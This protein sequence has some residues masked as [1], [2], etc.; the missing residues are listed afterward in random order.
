[1]D[2]RLPIFPLIA[3][4][5][6]TNA[7]AA[8]AEPP[9]RIEKPANSSPAQ[10]EKPPLNFYVAK[11]PDD[12][13]GAGCNEWIAA[14]GRF[15]FESYQRLRAFLNRLSGRKLPIYFSSP[16]GMVSQALAIGRLLRERGLTAGVASTTPQGCEPPADKEEACL[17]LKHSGRAVTAAWNAIDANCNSS[18]VYALLGGKQRQVPPGARLGVHSGKVLRV[19]RVGG[20]VKNVTDETSAPRTKAKAH[21]IDVELRRYAREMGIDP[22]LIDEAEKIPFEQVRYLSRDEIARFGIDARPLIET[23][24]TVVDVPSKPL[25][26]FTFMVEAKGGNNKEFRTGILRLACSSAATLAV[27]YIRGLAGDEIGH[28]ATIKL[29][30]S[31]RDLVFPRIGKVS[32]IDALDNG[33]TF[34]SR[35]VRAP[36]DFFDKAAAAE[37]IDIVVTDLADPAL[38]PR[39]RRLSTSGL[40]SA[41]E[42]LRR[43]CAAAP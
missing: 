24:W 19:V 8:P 39:V 13:C 33:A 23:R 6:C 10:P 37:N 1:M 30:A 12:A 35:A 40:G 27:A 15:D 42:V 16:G 29:T 34:D 25:A 20:D 18:C 3:L 4:A 7:A 21:E 2:F 32:K 26:V 17:A 36:L 9:P 28:V 41:V 31:G 38:A 22:G 11:G 14:E 5:F 43:R